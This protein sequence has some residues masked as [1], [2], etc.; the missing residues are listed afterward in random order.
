MEGLKENDQG[1]QDEG[2]EFLADI[3][4]SM[5][6]FSESGLP[7]SPTVFFPSLVPGPVHPRAQRVEPSTKPP[8]KDRAQREQKGNPVLFDH[9]SFLTSSSRFSPSCE[10]RY[11][12]YWSS[13]QWLKGWVTLAHSS[14][15]CGAVGASTLTSPVRPFLRAG[16]GLY[17]P[18]FSALISAATSP[19]CV[20]LEAWFR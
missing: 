10:K 5:A 11:L 12:P 2:A 18:V 9:M 7:L 15:G 3:S 16:S 20:H 8:L 17:P 19:T 14:A 1:W 4:S 6:F 13:V